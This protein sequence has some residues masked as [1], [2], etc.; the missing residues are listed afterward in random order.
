MVAGDQVN[1]DA[2]VGDFYQRFEGFLDDRRGDF[3][4]EKHISTM[5]DEVHFFCLGDIQ[6]MMV[7]GE[8][9][10]SA[11]PSLNSGMKREVEAEMGVGEEEDFYGVLGHGNSVWE[12]QM[13]VSLSI[14]IIAHMFC[15][16]E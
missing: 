8:E 1:G 4:P 11:S 2:R 5:D 16:V 15:F 6:D 14:M 9:V 7:I 10:M 12:F 13:G 3:A